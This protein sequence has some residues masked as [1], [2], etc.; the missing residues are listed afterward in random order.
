MVIWSDLRMGQKKRQTRTNREDAPHFTLEISLLLSFKSD[1]YTK[2]RF[3]AEVRCGGTTINDV[4]LHVSNSGL[5]FGGFGQSGIGSYHG[6][7]GFVAFSHMKSIYK[8]LAPEFMMGML[9]PPY[10]NSK[11]KM[12]NLFM[13]K[14]PRPKWR[15]NIRVSLV[16]RLTDGH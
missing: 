13:K 7:A 2:N 1:K 6:Y 12:L 3:E 15:P 14:N 16:M 4:I 9:R 11:I 8:Q 5:P 10:T